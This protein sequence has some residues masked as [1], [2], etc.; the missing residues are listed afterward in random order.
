MILLNVTL[1]IPVFVLV[2]VGTAALFLFIGAMLGKAITDN[3]SIQDRE[4]A[5]YMKDW[6]IK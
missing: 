5:G 4:E 1:S 3:P 2:I 6:R